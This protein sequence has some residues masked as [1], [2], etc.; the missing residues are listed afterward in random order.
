MKLAHDRRAKQTKSYEDV[1]KD[2][3]ENPK[4][5]RD[6]SGEHMKEVTKD[7]HI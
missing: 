1:I 5:N 4:E 7:T 2:N 6:Q 3:T